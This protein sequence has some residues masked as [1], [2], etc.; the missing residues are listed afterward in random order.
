LDGTS[1][2]IQKCWIGEK[3]FLFLVSWIEHGHDAWLDLKDVF[4]KDSTDVELTFFEQFSP[5]FAN[6]LDMFIG[7]TVIFDYRLDFLVFITQ[8]A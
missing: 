4:V 3:F 8:N 6:D 2:N 7:D 5:C 1:A